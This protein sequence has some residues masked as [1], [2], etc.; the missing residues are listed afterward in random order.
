MLNSLHELYVQAKIFTM[1]TSLSKKKI[2][3]ILIIIGMIFTIIPLF[4]T[5]IW[6]DESY[7]VSLA[8]HSFSQIWAIDIHDVHPVF[9]YDCLHVLY[10]IF[11]E[12]LLVYRLFSW[13]CLSMMGIFGYTGIR[14]DF[15]E[16]CG[17]WFT[18]LMFF[19]PVNVVYAGEIRMY[20]LVSL[21]VLLGTFYAIRLAKGQNSIWNHLRMVLYFI[22]AAYTHY[23]GLLAA[24]VVNLAL[25]IIL[26]KNFKK[27][28][29]KDYLMWLVDDILQIGCYV[30]WIFVFIAQTGSVKQNFWIKWIWPK[31]LIE[32][33][34]F[35]VSGNLEKEYFIPTALAAGLEICLVI[36]LI[37]NAVR[38]PRQHG[39]ET[40]LT[41]G[42][43][44]GVIIIAVIAGKQMNRIIIY[45]RYLLVCTSLLMCYFAYN[46][47]KFGRK[48][49]NAIFCI[50]IVICS[51]WTNLSLIKTNYDP[52]N[53]AP[54][55]YLNANMQ[56]GDIILV[57]NYKQDPNSFIAVSKYMDHPLIYWNEHGWNDESVKAYR[58]YGS[59]MTVVYDLYDLKNVKGRIW[60]IYADDDH[61]GKAVNH[62][63]DAVLDILGGS[64]DGTVY[65]STNYK[66]I[67]YTI[68]LVTV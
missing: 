55:D 6:F 61:N 26:I 20:M 48:T 36:Y 7:S 64:G 29:V 50:A 16:D 39:Y 11:G 44:A 15:G 10:L 53:Q 35:Q 12:N 4:Q 19:F 21:L 43:Y 2:H 38:H 56:E 3:L 17:L 40:A 37:Y 68:G 63:Y 62:V 51:V 65:F 57:S 32:I 5:N 33:L 1:K 42:T 45:A 52:V 60:V 47:A 13:A 58:A 34:M 66:N 49:V 67:E 25:L 31:S 18:F 14:R 41:L 54:Y 27:H 59:D 30:P 46:F 22:L 24:A 28:T 23:Y 9:Y 8:S